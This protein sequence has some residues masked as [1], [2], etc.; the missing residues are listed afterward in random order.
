MGVSYK[1]GD[2]RYVHDQPVSLTPWVISHGLG[3]FPGV[4][5]VDSDMS[6]IEADVR[7]DSLNQVTVTFAVP[8]AGKAFLS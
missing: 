4:T 8:V 5:L 6:E 2:A 1:P 7:H 3:K